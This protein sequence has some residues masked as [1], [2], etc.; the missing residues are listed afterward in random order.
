MFGHWSLD[1]N[2]QHLRDKSSMPVFFDTHEYFIDTTMINFY[3]NF[4][5][6]I[7]VFAVYIIS[8]CLWKIHSF[9]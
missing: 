8:L 7:W 9:M 5:Q 3:F 6:Q 4:V 1:I 2:A